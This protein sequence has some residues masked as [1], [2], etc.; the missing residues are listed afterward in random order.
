MVSAISDLF[1]DARA[2]ATDAD[3]DQLPAD[4]I[5]GQVLIEHLRPAGDIAD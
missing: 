5:A 1:T 3:I 2:F 4:V